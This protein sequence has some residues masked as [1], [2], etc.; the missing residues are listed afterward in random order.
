MASVCALDQ[1][2]FMIKFMI[3]GANTHGHVL[4]P[5]PATF[6]P[7]FYVAKFGAVDQICSVLSNFVISYDFDRYF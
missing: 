3:I 5:L 6:R 4:H 7:L 1:I 2:N